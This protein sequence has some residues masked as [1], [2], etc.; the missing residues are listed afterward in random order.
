VET[1]VTCC[2]VLFQMIASAFRILP[3]DFFTYTNA[4]ENVKYLMVGNVC[5]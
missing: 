2:M 4:L 1:D 5:D 3:G